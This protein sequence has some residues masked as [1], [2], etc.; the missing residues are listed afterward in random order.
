M[1][2]C[3][4]CDNCVDNA[5]ATKKPCR[6]FLK[7]I[8]LKWGTQGRKKGS[9]ITKEKTLPLS[10]FYITHKLQGFELRRSE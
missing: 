1:Y 2:K 6:L 3:L 9:F 8:E 5:R 4:H 7:T 10:G